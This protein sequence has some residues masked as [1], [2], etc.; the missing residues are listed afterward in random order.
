MMAPMPQ[1]QVPEPNI[2]GAE[3]GAQQWMYDPPNALISARRAQSA[4]VNSLL[5]VFASGGAGVPG[6]VAPGNID[7][8]KRPVVRNPDGSISTVRSMGIS[9]DGHEV[10]IPTVSDDGRLLSPQEAIGLFRQTGR[11][12]GIFSSPEASDAY[13]QQLHEDQA[14]MYGDGQ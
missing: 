8:T 9:V 3:F 4:P 5:G 14:R 6:M 10:L 2:R 7:L 13:A 1:A 12:L 11:H